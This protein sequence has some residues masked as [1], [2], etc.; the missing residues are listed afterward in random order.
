MDRIVAPEL[1]Q[2]DFTVDNL[3]GNLKKCIYDDSMRNKMISDYH[4]LK[5]KL[6]GSGASGRTAA[7]IMGELK[8]LYRS[9]AI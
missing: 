1:I 5:M 6:G 3:T 9:P 8:S 7:F 2:N 4:E